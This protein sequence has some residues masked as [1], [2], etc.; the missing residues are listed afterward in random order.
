M[1]N[2]K[3]INKETTLHK[4]GNSAVLSPWKRKGKKEKKG[5]TTRGIRI[6]SPIQ[7]LTLSN[8]A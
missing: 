8:R 6:W 7:V 5:I 2:K 4:N 1:R 3:L